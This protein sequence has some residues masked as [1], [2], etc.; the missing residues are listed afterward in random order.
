MP[1][2][3]AAAAIAVVLGSGLVGMAA[4]PAHADLWDCHSEIGGI[5]EN[6]AVAWCEAGQ[7]GVRVAATCNSAHWPYTRTVVGPWVG[8]SIQSWVKNP[9]G[10]HIVKAWPQVR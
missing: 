1:K 3:M 2:I 7:G 9:S 8:P 4:T 10:C 5:Y 6:W